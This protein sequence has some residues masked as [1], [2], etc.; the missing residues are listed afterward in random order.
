M[1]AS[2]SDIGPH[3]NKGKL[4][5]AGVADFA[6]LAGQFLAKSTIVEGFFLLVGSLIIP[7]KSSELFG[8]ETVL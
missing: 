6:H 5:L 7:A 1:D 3:V 8:V 4:T 2:I